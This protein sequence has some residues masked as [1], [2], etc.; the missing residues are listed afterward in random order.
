MK[1]IIKNKVAYL[2]FLLPALLFY[3]FAVFYPIIDSIRLSF[4]SWG[5]IGPQKYVGFD[6]YIR[7]FS[8]S[9]MWESFFNNLVYVVIVVSMQLLIGLLFAVLLTYMQKNVTIVKTLYYIPCIITTVAVG[10]MFRSMYATQPMG[11]LISC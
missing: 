4:V 5:G 7:L 3:L 8:D 1:G 2:V 9:V 11:C 10:Q 6:N